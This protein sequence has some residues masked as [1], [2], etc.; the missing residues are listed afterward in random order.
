MTFPGFLFQATTDASP[1]SSS[2][3]NPG[4]LPLSTVPNEKGSQEVVEV[5]DKFIPRR[6]TAIPPTGKRR[7]FYNFT[8][9]LLL[10][11]TAGG[12]LNIV[13]FVGLINLLK[14]ASLA[15]TWELVLEVCRI[16]TSSYRT[17]NEKA[18]LQ[19]NHDSPAE[20]PTCCID[21]VVHE[22]PTG[23]TSRVRELHRSSL[24]VLSESVC[25]CLD[26]LQDRGVV[27]GV[28]LCCSVP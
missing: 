8:M 16:L 5:K 18:G 24:G 3:P 9:K 2:S 4:S 21:A 22:Y 23:P 26:A 6:V 7:R 1:S 15:R 25:S 13:L 17:A 10:D 20:V 11:Q 12:I 27:L 14:G 28:V 19:T